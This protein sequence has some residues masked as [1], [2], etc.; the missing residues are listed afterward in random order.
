[1]LVEHAEK[2]L[3][4]AGLFDQDSDYS[5]MLGTWVLDLIKMFAEQGH[6]GSSAVMAAELF[7]RLSS[8]EV[9]TPPKDDKWND[10]DDL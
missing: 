5:G 3:R 4:A 2:E 1:M 8:Y 7:Y 9:L 10:V 6:S